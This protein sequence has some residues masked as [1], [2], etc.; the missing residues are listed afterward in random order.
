MTKRGQSVRGPVSGCHVMFRIT[1]PALDAI[2]EETGKTVPQ[3][4]LNWLLQRPTVSSVIVGA[5]NE[6]QLRQN[7]GAVGWSHDRCAGR[8]TRRGERGASAVSVLPVSPATGV[9]AAQSADARVSGDGQPG[10]T[11]P[12]RHN[13]GT[14][15][16]TH[17]PWHQKPRPPWAYPARRELPIVAVCVVVGRAGNTSNP[18]RKVRAHERHRR[19][20]DRTRGPGRRLRPLAAALGRL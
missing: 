12:K 20:P 15:R 5:C 14:P 18:H 2:A 17:L 13:A 19:R 6:E 7:L 11:A 1:T 3:I 10:T 16:R 8:E 4:A 9:R